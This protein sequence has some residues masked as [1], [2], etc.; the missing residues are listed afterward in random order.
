M[1]GEVQNN[2]NPIVQARFIRKSDAKELDKIREDY[3]SL[4]EK[5]AELEAKG[6]SD[7]AQETRNLAEGA[8]LVYEQKAQELGLS[9]TKVEVANRGAEPGNG[10]PVVAPGTRLTKAQKKEIEE[11]EKQL[12]KYKKKLD[13]YS[14]E[15][16][17]KAN[18]ANV[19]GS[20]ITLTDDIKEILY[21]QKELAKAQ[22]QYDIKREEY[23]IPSALDIINMVY[24]IEDPIK[25][26]KIRKIVK[27]EL[28]DANMYFGL[29]KD[30]LNDD[31]L[32]NVMDVLAIRNEINSN[33]E[34]GYVGTRKKLVERFKDKDAAE[35]AAEYSQ[36]SG[37]DLTFN[38]RS[39]ERRISQAAQNVEYFKEPFID[40][41]KDKALNELDTILIGT[42]E[43]KTSDITRITTLAGGVIT[44]IDGFD[45]LKLGDI[46]TVEVGNDQYDFK[47]IYKEKGDENY[48]KRKD[49]KRL[50]KD[51]G[52]KYDKIKVGKAIAD[53]ALVGIPSLAAAAL[54]TFHILINPKNGISLTIDGHGSISSSVFEKMFE[55]IKEQAE[56]MQ[57]ENG[58]K[59]DVSNLGDVIAF[60]YLHEYKYETT[61]FCA[62]PVITSAAVAFVASIVEQAL[63][64]EEISTEKAYHAAR[65]KL[66]LEMMHNAS[67]GDGY[68]INK[69]ELDKAMLDV[70]AVVKDMAE[71]PAVQPEKPVKE[72]VIKTQDVD[73]VVKEAEDC[74][75]YNKPGEYWDGIVRLGYVD[76]NGKPI[77][78]EADIAELRS[79][80]KGKLNGFAPSSADMPESDE[81]KGV[82]TKIRKKY[83]CKSGNTYF[84]SLCG[85][86]PDAALRDKYTSK[87]AARDINGNLISSRRVAAKVGMESTI[88]TVTPAEYNFSWQDV[89]DSREFGGMRFDNRADRDAAVEAEKKGFEE[90]KKVKYNVKILNGNK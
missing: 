78:N 60:D 41:N 31:T 75:Y 15:E 11:L 50:G 58:G 4:M 37:A 76:A 66:N 55:E 52:F 35:V 86:E 67:G 32:K 73:P 57:A 12:K 23:N 74:I 5:A 25:A 80:T 47:P 34:R 7:K 59:I 9:I 71:T 56:K 46:R 8:A 1:T 62:A 63:A 22:S 21:Y 2:T 40:E 30:A 90:H 77:T 28:K 45:G 10:E 51:I 29:T 53:A 38:R 82:G 72:V 43:I 49:I 81:E 42:T 83:T 69:K 39:N 36:A 13:K 26:S 18:L 89:N 85:N 44:N 14:E 16:I 48:N 20:N 24:A 27:K 19:A 70:I 87:E 88:S 61:H 79:F 65:A 17:H 33:L 54:S 68:I 6:K 64:K 3:V 84:W